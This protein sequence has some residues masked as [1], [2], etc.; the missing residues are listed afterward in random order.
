MDVNKTLELTGVTDYEA[1]VIKQGY[2]K[3]INGKGCRYF[4]GI[5]NKRELR[6]IN[7]AFNYVDIHSWVSGAIIGAAAVG[8]YEV[9][10]RS[11]NKNV[12]VKSEGA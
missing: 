4:G 7:R 6:D 11:K 5:L 1:V 3:F 9:Y 12:E 8:L 2:E 10:K